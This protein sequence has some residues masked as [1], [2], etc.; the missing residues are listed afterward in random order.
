MKL[1]LT[2]KKLTLASQSC[3]IA[4]VMPWG[5]FNSSVVFQEP[6]VVFGHEVRNR[7]RQAWLK[8]GQGLGH[9]GHDSGQ[10]F[11]EEEYPRTPLHQVPF[12]SWSFWSSEGY[13]VFTTIEK[14]EYL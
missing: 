11:A 12:F 14:E 7:L 10:T 9:V 4:H 3:S 6:Q 13:S 5:H 1:P 2:V 8:Q